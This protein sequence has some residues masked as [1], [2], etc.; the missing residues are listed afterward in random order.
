LQQGAELNAQHPG[1]SSIMRSLA[2]PG[3]D[4][5]LLGA[6]VFDG[7]VAADVSVRTTIGP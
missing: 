3:R 2:I 4:W 1:F 5:F 6:Q 7:F